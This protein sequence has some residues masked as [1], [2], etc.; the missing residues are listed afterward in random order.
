MV[1]K[2]RKIK[3]QARVLTSKEAE[4]MNIPQIDAI[5]KIYLDW[6]IIQ[7]KLVNNP[8]FVV[9]T[10]RSYEQAKEYLKGTRIEVL[11]LYEVPA[12]EYY[13]IDKEIVKNNG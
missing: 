12:G 3:A 2:V 9:G 4:E 8:C 7:S 10:Q 6:A 13:L 5:L 11:L 1:V